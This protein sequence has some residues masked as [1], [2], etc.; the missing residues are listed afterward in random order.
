[1]RLFIHRTEYIVFLL[2]LVLLSGCAVVGPQSIS[3]GRAS[4]AEA[5]NKTEDEQVLL[6]IVKGRYGET[7][8][9]LAVSGVAANMR[10]RAEAG[11]EAAFGPD[12][13]AGENLLLGGFAYE[14][15]PTITYAPVQGEK[16]IR[17]LMSPIPLE[18]L[19][20]SLRSA[21]FSDRVLT[22][23]VTRA[24]GLH[25]PDFEMV[26][27][28]D[29]KRD[30]E[31]FVELFSEL[32]NVGAL[33]LS[34]NPQDEI[35][36]NLLIEGYRSRY[37]N[38]VNEFL[39]LLNLPLP[40]DDQG[41]L[42]IPVSFA[43]NTEKSWGLGLTTR[44]TFDLVEILRAS[45]EIPEE[46][47]SAGLSVD[48]P[49]K[50]LPGQGIEIL[51]SKEKPKDMS[52]AVPYRGYWFYIPSNDQQTKAFFSVLRILWSISIAGAIEQ[53]DAPVLTLPVGR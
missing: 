49:P 16:Y 4:Y 3:A 33:D 38:E 29:Q 18:I 20:L 31:R 48:Y 35:A 12:S 13:R 15:N 50:G 53:A 22:F 52:L 5:I 7:Y 41:E 46:H 45:V 32:H 9:L 11:I 34:K 42:I 23:L 51:S 6:S 44:S 37:A 24:N 36:F 43:I 14:E 19:M 17:E 21:T 27:L 28:P 1:M 25:N 47:A 39:T 30:F 2:V 8:S 10:F 26:S 40:K